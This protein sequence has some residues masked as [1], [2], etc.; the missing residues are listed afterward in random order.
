MKSD[1]CPR[2]WKGLRVECLET[3]WFSGL[4]SPWK[5]SNLKVLNYKS[6]HDQLF[7]QAKDQCQISAWN[8]TGRLFLLDFFG[9]WA[10]VLYASWRPW[11]LFI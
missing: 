5:F 11:S 4:S 3:T 1:S 10:A 2:V 7:I 9:I 8:N 6:R